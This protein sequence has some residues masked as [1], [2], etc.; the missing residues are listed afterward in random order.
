MYDDTVSSLRGCNMLVK[1]RRQCITSMP[2]VSRVA[3]LAFLPSSWIRSSSCLVTSG[4]R[5]PEQRET[6]IAKQ[7]FFG[8][9]F[10]NN[11]YLLIIF[12]QCTLGDNKRLII[13]GEVYSIGVGEF[14]INNY[15]LF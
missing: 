10:L 15:S 5:D 8:H 2:R 9:R 7:Q 12:L 13:E 11:N 4:F 14:E 6:Y 1:G 3:R